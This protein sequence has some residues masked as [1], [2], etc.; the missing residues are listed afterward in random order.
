MALPDNSPTQS[1]A[2]AALCRYA[3][4]QGGI[5]HAPCACQFG[6]PRL[7]PYPSRMRAG[8]GTR[9]QRILLHHPTPQPRKNPVNCASVLARSP[10]VLPLKTQWRDEI[11]DMAA[12]AVCDNGTPIFTGGASC[13]GPRSSRS[14]ERTM[15]TARGRPDQVRGDS[16]NLRVSVYSHALVK[17]GLPLRHRRESAD[18]TER[19]ILRL[20]HHGVGAGTLGGLNVRGWRICRRREIRSSAPARQEQADKKFLH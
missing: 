15:F 8:V 18:Q 7:A 17:D 16:M 14:R 11:V 3:M 2:A 4:I 20:C 13:V 9:A 12:M 5:G 19:H 10:G 1:P 6:R